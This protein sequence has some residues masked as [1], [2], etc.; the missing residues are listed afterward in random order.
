MTVSLCVI[1]LEMCKQE[2]MLPFLMVVII[3]A[4]GVADRIGDSIIL[5]RI[6]LKCLPFIQRMPH[7]SMRRGRFSAANIVRICDNPMLPECARS[8]LPRRFPLFLDTLVHTSGT[9]ST[10]FSRMVKP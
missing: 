5:R 10:L 8:F 9:I 3:V 6:K 1:M 2:G 7:L 4:K